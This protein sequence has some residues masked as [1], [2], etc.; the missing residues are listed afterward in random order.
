VTDPAHSE[1]VVLDGKSLKLE[2]LVRVAR[3]PR[4]KVEIAD[5]AMELV[6]QSQ[7]Q[8]QEIVR[9][10]REEY[11]KL[12]RE[13][14][15]HPVL[16][17]G[18]TTGFGEFKNIPVPP[19]QL[20]ELQCNILLS[21]AVGAG[22]TADDLHPSNYFEPEVVRAAL[23]IRLNAFLKGHSGIR[24]EMVRVVQAMVNR[25]VI[26]LVPIRG[27]VGSSGDLC[28]L[29]HLFVVVL[30]EG[31]YFLVREPDD[32]L[33]RSRELRSGLEQLQE[34][35]GIP[36]PRPSYKEGLALTNGATFTAALLGL[37]VYDAEH[38]AKV[39]DA[40]LALSL[41][42]VCGCARAFDPR[43]HEVRGHAGQI[44]SAEHVRELLK[45]SSLIEKAG[46]VQDVYSLRCAPTVHGAARDTIAYAR[47]AVEAEMNAATDNPLFFGQGGKDP[48]DYEFKKNWPEGYR[49]D[50]RISFSA[51]NFHGEPV[52]F[53]SDFLAIGLAELASISER[54][55]Q[56]LLD[57]HHNRNLPS[58]LIPHR[59][60]NSGWMIAQYTAAGI[61]S[62]NKVLSHPA[63][64]DSIPT[65]ANSED[66]N[67]MGIIAARKLRTVLRNAQAVLAIELLVAVQAV[68]WRVAMDIDPR[69]KDPNPE[70][71]SEAP[72]VRE[73]KWEAAE[74]EARQFRERTAPDR[75]DVIAESLGRGT[76]RVYRKVRD[77]AP[78]LLGDD[79]TLDGDLRAVR[80]AVER[81]GLM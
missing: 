35:L 14:K 18:I 19:E 62:E 7:E 12:R 33:Y 41:E 59:G 63:S 11:E 80:W 8:I 71:G 2:D 54:R 68:E 20:E 30:G 61:V 24:Q 67:A 46:A 52:G 36:V 9:K 23:V 64:V 81:N 22:E 53:A 4:V 39:A 34:D 48:W 58:N 31:R 55:T 74:K 6:R 75:R 29:S 65:S 73:A 57:G 51:G 69:A 37:G 10:Y 13:E 1:R 21:H 72:V 26:P 76:R 15:A 45:E 17:Y 43:V 40:A 77:L 49:G 42:A 47:T 25:G 28:P 27:S 44:A 56:M 50:Q 16:D 60:V 3:D 32:L 70:M 38:L 5:E 66:H 79:R 78:P